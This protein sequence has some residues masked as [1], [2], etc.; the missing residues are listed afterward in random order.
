[1]TTEAP[2]LEAITRTIVERFQPRRIILFGS[3]ARGEARP[4]SDIDLF[5]EM[6]TSRRPPE[7]SAEISAAFGLRSWSMDVVVYTPGEVA[8]LRPIS[9]N[10]LSIIERE[11]RILYERPTNEL[12]R[13]DEQG[14]Q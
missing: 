10:L 4:D 12:P 8:R 13:L 2:P 6:E 9:G 3:Q 14:R 5:V 7:R 1:M 11:G